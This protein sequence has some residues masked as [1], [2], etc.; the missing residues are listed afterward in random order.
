MGQQHYIHICI[1]LI[2]LIANGAVI[3]L[4]FQNDYILSAWGFL[5]FLCLHI[6][7]F[8]DYL[9]HMFM[10]IEKSI[11][12]LLYDDYSNIIT[13][14]RKANPLHNKTAKLLN[15][16]RKRSIQETSDKLIY[17]NIIE[18]LSIGVLILKKTNKVI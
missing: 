9:N 12:C 2:L 13:E 14:Q 5:F 4:C 10:D 3:F 16:N 8:I 11:D 7:L 18:S 6:F 15:K 17:N 1:R